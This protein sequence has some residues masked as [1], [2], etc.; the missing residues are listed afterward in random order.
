[1]GKS[2][3]EL[4]RSALWTSLPILSVLFLLAV[5]IFG[6]QRT[7]YLANL[8]SQQAETITVAER[9]IRNELNS[10][11]ADTTT[12]ARSGAAEIFAERLSF[13]ASA[14]DLRTIADILTDNLVAFADSSQHYS[15]LRVLDL[16]GIEVIRV[17]F[18]D[19]RTVIVQQENLQDK[20]NRYYFQEALQLV[21]GNV[22]VSPFDLNEE[23]GQLDIPFNPTL[24]AVTPIQ[25]DVSGEIGA[26][27]VLN[28]SGERILGQLENLESHAGED[29][30]LANSQG[31]LFTG[32]M[33]AM[34]WGFMFDNGRENTLA[35]AF[36]EIW[37]ELQYQQSNNLINDNRM[38]SFA[39]ICD[40]INCQDNFLNSSV[41][42]Q[43]PFSGADFPWLILVYQPVDVISMMNS[44]NSI[45]SIP[46]LLL[47]LLLGVFLLALRNS[48]SLAER[49]EALR[50]S[51]SELSQLEQLL[52][53]FLNYSSTIA[54]A[55]DASGRFKLVNKAFSGYV[56]KSVT[57][58]LGSKNGQSEYASPTPLDDVERDVLATGEKRVQEEIWID[59]DSKE[60]RNVIVSRFP[61]RDLESKGDLVGVIALDI[62]QTKQQRDEL[63]E[64]RAYLE[65][66]VKISPNGIMS[67][68]EYGKIEYANEYIAKA[69][70]YSQT[71]LLGMSVD[72][73]V[74]LTNR[75]GHKNLR[76]KYRESPS[77]RLMQPNRSV[78]AQRKNG[79]TFD[80]EVLL[81]PLE[82]Q[83]RK[84]TL[85]IL[86]DITDRVKM[87]DHLRQSQKMEA[88]GQLTGGVAHDFNNLLGI[89]IGNIELLQARLVNDT[90]SINRLEKI[91]YAADRGAEL[92][93][94]LL[95][96][97]RRQVLNAELVDVGESLDD[98]V[99][100]IGKTLSDKIDFKVSLPEKRLFVFL[101]RIELQNAFLNLAINSRDAMPDGGT[102]TLQ[103][104]AVYL[105]TD[106]L[107]GMDEE[108]VEGEYVLI[109]FSDSGTGISSKNLPHIFEPFFTTKERDKGTGLGLSMV[110][111]F[112]KQSSG[113]VKVYSELDV[114]TSFHIYFPLHIGAGVV[115]NNER[116][117]LEA[118][119][120]LP[121]GSERIL[122]VDDE[123][124]LA[125]IAFETLLALGYDAVTA[126]SAEDAMRILAHEAHFD[127]VITDIVMPGGMDGIELR[128]EIRKAYPALKCIYT[129]G[130][131]AE[132][133]ESN[134]RKSLDEKLLR[135]PFMRRDFALIVREVLDG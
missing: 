35:S 121:K 19:G 4:T 14:E 46:Y 86:R 78:K 90:H 112:V 129:S 83:D 25:G 127:L 29:L 106:F 47:V 102:L 2:L 71:D 77:A 97:A 117:S 18:Q 12:L 72:N 130:F 17:E 40:D 125:D 45:T 38:F 93:K 114:G 80:I 65:T 66:L 131:S 10:L 37:Q 88:I 20:S 6:L 50:E 133:L 9:I 132:A 58:L 122:I 59:P 54:Y 62:T 23:N 42:S 126:S 74:P 48:V 64:R 73:L 55:K 115:A 89:I 95:A 36:P 8:T 109:T 63:E 39:Y 82:Y 81:S 51:N 128:Q 69:F 120:A 43:L 52:S 3:V 5:T 113:M 111:G 84:L 92:T 68:D 85:V 30:I 96:F 27:L 124:E 44:L 135:K 61:V 56:G 21:A 101:D 119:D 28:Y 87:E 49:S 76:E 94:R 24:R 70:G 91:L 67:V 32:M 16:N 134:K 26:Y 7:T 123:P 105:G 60:K 13:G 22:A 33:E 107:K 118:L 98:A 53:G 34:R 110:H 79:T 57:Q 11:R 99:K 75:S 103:A 100:L 41:V 104:E 116:E 108:L 31:Y 1:M 15:Q